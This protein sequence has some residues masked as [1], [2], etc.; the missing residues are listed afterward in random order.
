[1]GQLPLQIRNA[2]RGTRDIFGTLAGLRS[3]C[4]HRH[5]KDLARWLFISSV[6][7]PHFH[8]GLRPRSIQYIRR[9]PRILTELKQSIYELDW[10]VYWID[11]H[12]ATISNF[13]KAR[14]QF[15][16]L[17]LSAD[18]DSCLS[19]LDQIESQFGH[20]Q[21][22]IDTRLFLL[23]NGKGLEAQK[24]FLKQVRTE[25]SNFL[26]EFLTYFASVRNEEKTNPYSFRKM[27]TEGVPQWLADNPSLQKYVILKLVAPCD[28]RADSIAEILRREFTSPVIDYYETFV[29]LALQCAVS[30]SDALGAV[31]ESVLA[32]QSRITDPRLS[33]L[34]F[35]LTGDCEYLTSCA[36]QRLNDLDKWTSGEQA[37][38]I[39]KYENSLPQGIEALL[40]LSL[41]NAEF[42][43]VPLASASSISARVAQSATKIALKKPGSEES[44]L[45][46]IRLGDNSP[47]ASFGRT[48]ALFSDSQMAA[49]PFSA[50]ETGVSATIRAALLSPSMLS[51][52][53]QTGTDRISDLLGSRIGS[54]PSLS[55]ERVRAGINISEQELELI[56]EP[57]RKLA[58]T[59]AAYS[60]GEFDLAAQ[61]SIRALD[62]HSP[63][64]NRKFIRL[65]INAYICSGEI[66][67]AVRLI[68]NAYLNDPLI[69]PMLPL[70]LCFSKC[71]EELLVEIRGELAVPI[72]V[73]L[74]SRHVEEHSSELRYAFED[75]LAEHGME[76]P[77][78]LAS[79]Q[80]KFER[81]AL[82][83]FLRFVCIP[84]VMQLSSPFTSS[85]KLEDER[86]SVCSLLKEIDAR[87]A[88][89]YDAEIREI[90]R[91]QGIR[92]GLREVESS[93][94]WVDQEGLRRW[95]TK[96]LDE[97]FV[98]FQSLRE[99][100]TEADA[101]AEE[102]G[103]LAPTTD[104]PRVDATTGLPEL[105][106]NEVASL[107]VTMITQFLNQCFFDP[108]NGLDCFLSL[109]VRHG[110]LSG[111]MRGPL[112]AEK[113]VTLQRSPGSG[114]Y[115]SNQ[116]WL[117]RLE[118]IDRE[119]AL[120][121]DDKLKAFSR[122][123]DNLIE[124]FARD[125]IQIKSDTKPF[126]LFQASFPSSLAV[127]AL[128][129]IHSE[130]RLD[131]F[132]DLCF[133]VFW[134]SVDSSL[135]NI[136]SYVDTLLAPKLNALFLKLLRDVDELTLD[137]PTSELDNAIRNAQT[138]VTHALEQ[139]KDWFRQPQPLAPSMITL[140]ELIDISVQAVK[141]M[142]RDFIPDL[143]LDIPALP[144][145]VQ[146][147]RFTDIFIILLDNIWR[148]SGNQANPKVKIKVRL[149]DKNLRIEFRN[150]VEKGVRGGAT[151]KRVSEIQQKISQGSYQR[152]V[153][154]EGGTGLMKIHNIFGSEREGAAVLQFYF[155]SDEWFF[156]GLT[157]TMTLEAVPSEG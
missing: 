142:H 31:T 33:K 130:T 113:I 44:R 67:R 25:S 91:A 133:R 26:V 14:S 46:L 128:R 138:R 1:M 64:F 24:T 85:R 100:L 88:A 79:I 81:S 7:A 154:S 53:P 34:A 41:A 6:R 109:R 55:L 107:F 103:K 95:A 28:G 87:N 38:L 12:S 16:D 99:A 70:K 86:L 69:L 32:L 5:L 116:F 65:A 118:K 54:S 114:E 121:V 59:E 23:Q 117:S 141:K 45:E 75:L 90:T 157:L 72:F 145:F 63:P 134:E 105:P 149:A 93:K 68:S 48:L 60:R 129:D 147:H 78:E 97:S 21:W 112:E 82:T 27:I 18:C 20:S 150:S 10:G 52:V 136:R 57:L 29:S 19:S 119:M 80:A 51:F 139:V 77:S 126:G 127:M 102:P 108:K 101:S 155:E 106:V 15:E 120:R 39:Q 37:E 89:V 35:Q 58:Q 42:G 84:S 43:I 151:E 8:S 66:K 115:V 104:A 11:L 131:G 9:E 49:S 30:G 125:C 3:T 146:V 152:A 61:L 143:E 135:D 74:L 71:T 13:L 137:L 110:A 153:T 156:V 40:A 96:N 94:I 22:G 73:D 98:R 17:L 111:Q 140:D 83:Y 4:S 2:L 62:R 92:K 132:L 122:D 144:P 36:V 76:R 123:F 50:H 148:H 56:Q 47:W 124:G